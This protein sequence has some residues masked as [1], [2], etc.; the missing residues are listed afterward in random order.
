M[1]KGVLHFTLFSRMMKYSIT[2]STLSAGREEEKSARNEEGRQK[3]M[4]C[5]RRGVKEKEGFSGRDTERHGQASKCQGEVNSWKRDLC[6]ELGVCVC[7]LT[8]IHLNTDAYAYLF[9]CLYMSSKHAPR[10]E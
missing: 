10:Q 3:H 6:R 4:K 9:V 2:D 5:N 8:H 1:K 7:V